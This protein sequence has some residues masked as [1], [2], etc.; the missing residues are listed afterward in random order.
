M[1]NDLE[2]KV[3]FKVACFTRLNSKQA[4]LT[5][6]YP[7]EEGPSA[8]LQMLFCE[9]EAEIINHLFLHCKETGRISVR[10]QGEIEDSPSLHLVD[11]LAEKES[12]MF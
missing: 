4:G 10:A 8:V 5:Q 9:C 11:Y 12:E 1:E 3:S 7:Y 6:E 2:V